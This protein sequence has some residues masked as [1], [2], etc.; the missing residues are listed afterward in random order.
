MSKIFLR[1][2]HDTKNE[3]Q[4]NKYF[5]D[6]SITIREMLKDFLK[7]TNSIVTLD[8]GKIMFMFGT[9]ILNKDKVLDMKVGKV[10]N[11]QNNKLIKIIDNEK[12]V[13]GIVFYNFIHY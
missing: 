6:A 10:F 1:F 8:P 5:F 3:I 13:G 11:S 4:N 7:Q 2:S 9:K 12:I